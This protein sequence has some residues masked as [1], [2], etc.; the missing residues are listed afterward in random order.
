MALYDPPE[1]K[2]DTKREEY[3]PMGVG[4]ALYSGPDDGPFRCGMCRHFAEGGKCEHPEVIEG[5]THG[6]VEAGGCCKYYR[7]VNSR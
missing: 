7:K 4:H 2:K 5:P 6:R 3:Q 1:D